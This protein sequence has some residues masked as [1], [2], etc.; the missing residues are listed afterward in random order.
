M[1]MYIFLNEVAS[2]AI[3]TSRFVC[4]LFWVELIKQKFVITKCLPLTCFVLNKQNIY[5]IVTKFVLYK[6]LKIQDD[7]TRL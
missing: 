3:L 5:S 7:N 1:Y 2:N 4:F 6:I